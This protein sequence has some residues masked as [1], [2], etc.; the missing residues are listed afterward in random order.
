[1]VV[2]E[3]IQKPK[4]LLGKRELGGASVVSEQDGVSS[5]SL[6]SGVF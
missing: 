2:F 1:M 4:S 3:L 6:D 5:L